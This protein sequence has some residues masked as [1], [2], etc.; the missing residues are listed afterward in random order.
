MS[1]DAMMRLP[2]SLTAGSSVHPRP[3]LRARTRSKLDE[4]RSGTCSALPE[5][6]LIRLLFRRLLLYLY[7]PGRDDAVHARVRHQLPEVLVCIR[8]QNV[9]YVPGVR[10]RTQLRQQLCKIRVAHTVDRL[11]REL[12][13]PVQFLDDLGFLDR[14]FFKRL[15]VKSGG[16]RRS[17]EPQNPVA[18]ARDVQKHF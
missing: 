7:G 18:L 12:P 10:L 17:H 9:H 2:F 8:D 13:R 5:L 6:F 11:L 15:P 1:T 3:S 14:G 4:L 16:W